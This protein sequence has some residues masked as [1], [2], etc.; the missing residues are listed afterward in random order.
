[1]LL[2]KQ[3]KKCVYY[4]EAASLSHK[5][6]QELIHIYSFCFRPIPS[7][8]AVVKTKQSAMNSTH[9]YLWCR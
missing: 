5:Y 2:T 8:L 1:M 3:N 4:E 6:F 9:L 7:G